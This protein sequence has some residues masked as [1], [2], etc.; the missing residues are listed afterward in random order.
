MFTYSGLMLVRRLQR[1]HNFTTVFVGPVVFTEIFPNV[2][3]M[4]VHR[5][6]RWTSIEP[7]LGKR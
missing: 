6:R 3:S 2:G 4:L 5:L 7:E 1:W